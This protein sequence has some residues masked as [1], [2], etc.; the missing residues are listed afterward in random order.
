MAVNHPLVFINDRFIRAK[1]AHLHISDLG[2]LRGFAIFDFLAV[3]A[4]VPIFLS[5]HLD[6][7]YQS[8]KMLDLKC[9]IGNKAMSE[10]IMELI[11]INKIKIGAIRIILTGGYSQDAYTPGEPNLIL[12]PDQL[13]VFNPGYSFHGISLMT[14]KHQRE[15]P[16]IKTTNYLTGIYL[17]KQLQMS[18]ADALLYHDGEYVLESDRS[19]FFL[20]NQYGELLTP[21][22]NIL[23]G[24]TRMKIIELAEM[25]GIKVIKRQVE[26]TELADAREMFMTNTSRGVL[27]VNMLDGTLV[28][29]E[30]GATTLF[31]KDQL[32]KLIENEIAAGLA[33]NQEKD[34]IKTLF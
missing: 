4:G 30:P 19:N 11:Q 7:F 13:P 18:R 10:L 27:A 25:S 1:N 26:L 12:I 34:T 14:H 3:R 21:S 5:D 20:V 17:K 23:Q 6:R 2:L 9:R 28:G 29:A 31:L 24:I 33:N 8:A 22:Q 32:E 16:S 15:L